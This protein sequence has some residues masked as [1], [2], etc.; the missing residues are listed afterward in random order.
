MKKYCV[1][2][3]IAPEPDNRVYIGKTCQPPLQRW[4]QGYDGNIV[5]Q[6]AIEEF[7]KVVDAFE[8]YILASNGEDWIPWEKSMSLRDTNHFGFEE[9]CE[10]ETMW[11]AI[12]ES[13]DFR[14][15]FNRQSG[16]E[17]GFVLSTDAKKY[18]SEITVGRYA[19]DKNPMYG[20]NQTDEGKRRLSEIAKQR[21]GAKNGM[22]GKHHTEET[23][24]RNRQAHLGRYDGENNP[25]HGQHH[26]AEKRAQLS[27]QKSKPIS[28]YTLDGRLVRTFPSALVAAQEMGVAVQ[29]ISMCATKNTKTSC[30][31]VWRY[32]EIEQL[33]KEDLPTKHALCKTVAQYDTQGNNIKTYNSLKEAAK[34]LDVSLGTI[35]RAAKD[36]TKTCKGYIFK[37]VN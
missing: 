24:E 1:Y 35:S 26:S 13:L 15:G 21:T 3:H 31:M 4:R 17:Q 9:A 32:F 2:K 10:L 22:W 18:M 34:A 19:G 30:G 23:K 14:R 7:G 20:K 37:Y 25:F 16:G 28:M 11:I 36:K 6:Y 8:H 5:F 29:S 27:E 33:P 12:Y